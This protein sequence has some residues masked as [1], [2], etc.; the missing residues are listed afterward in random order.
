MHAG[1][2]SSSNV[3]SGSVYGTFRDDKA[4]PPTFPMQHVS[5]VF[6]IILTYS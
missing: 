6:G 2:G 1:S 4:H 5:I 3:A